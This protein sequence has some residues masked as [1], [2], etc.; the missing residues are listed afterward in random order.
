MLCE[1]LDGWDVGREV[2]E[3]ENICI[4]IAGLPWWLRW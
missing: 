1:D 2:Q 4:H 3:E